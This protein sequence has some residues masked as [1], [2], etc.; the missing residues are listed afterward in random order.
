MEKDKNFLQHE[1]VGEF[2]DNFINKPYKLFRINA[3]NLSAFLR[4][5]YKKIHGIPN[6]EDLN[7]SGFSTKG[8]DEKRFD[9]VFETGYI[10][11][12]AEKEDFSDAILLDGYRRLFTMNTP[13]FPVFVR[14]FN[15]KDLSVSEQLKLM[16][17]Y[18][19]WKIFTKSGWGS[20][21]GARE[22][23]DRGMSLF[24]FLKTGVNIHKIIEEFLYYLDF[25]EVNSGEEKDY[26]TFFKLFFEN[27]HLFD[28]IKFIHALKNSTLSFTFKK[29][30][31]KDQKIPLDELFYRDIRGIRFQ[32]LNKNKEIDFKPQYF[33][34]SLE[35]IEAAQE[36]VVDYNESTQG[37]KLRRCRDTAREH[38]IHYFLKEILKI[39]AEKSE[40]EIKYEDEKM[41]ESFKRKHVNLQETSRAYLGRDDV[42][43]FV[44]KLRVGVEYFVINE[45]RERTIFDSNLKGKKDINEDFGIRKII[46]KEISS[47]EAT[48]T[49]LGQKYMQTVLHFLN[50]RG[51]MIEMTASVA[52]AKGF[53]VAKENAEVKPKQKRQEFYIIEYHPY[54]TP[55]KFNHLVDWEGEKPMA[56]YI[57][58]KTKTRVCEIIN[59]KLDGRVNA[60]YISDY[61]HDLSHFEDLRELMK[62]FSECVAY[63][64]GEFGH[65][66]NARILKE[67]L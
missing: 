38:S 12:M 54:R 32:A 48:T 22:Y 15:P 29:K 53:Y 43:K 7:N 23:F 11:L 25:R 41:F 64:Y 42:S 60:S 45:N 65:K 34:D 39:R 49:K 61:C 5:N 2:T 19:F 40:L 33:I 31:M 21:V 9:H 35:K 46:L 27:K 62:D 47:R 26:N 66:E 18:N 67:V 36:L 20:S 6:I 63:G 4:E 50:E 59:E 52:N 30:E 58:A 24:L 44:A 17:E 10:A 51:E 3:R 37:E 13:D 14:V 8:Y 16:H 56:F 28:D 55:N 57:K 1:Y